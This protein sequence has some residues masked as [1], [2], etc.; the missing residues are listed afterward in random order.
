M[1]L[2]VSSECTLVHNMRIAARR[3]TACIG[4]DRN[5]F[6]DRRER[7]KGDLEL[8]KETE[9]DVNLN[10]TQFNAEKKQ[11][12]KKKERGEEEK[13]RKKE[14]EKRKIMIARRRRRSVLRRCSKK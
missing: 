10:T 12:R 1:K 9:F 7:G 2:K 8:R 5:G 6:E 4:G 3:H 11:R 14:R 13:G